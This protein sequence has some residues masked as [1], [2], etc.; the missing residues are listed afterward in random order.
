MVCYRRATLRMTA[1][2][3]STAALDSVLRS[4]WALPAAMIVGTGWR[5]A[6][7]TRIAAPRSTVALVSVWRTIQVV[8][9]GRIKTSRQKSAGQSWHPVSQIRIAA[10]P[11]TAVSA[12]A[13]RSITCAEEDTE[14]QRR[15]AILCVEDLNAMSYLE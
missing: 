7:P 14:D 3:H 13:S 4:T 9:E 8:K 2:L 1:A 6:P 12:T 11:F 10:H 5:R 15:K